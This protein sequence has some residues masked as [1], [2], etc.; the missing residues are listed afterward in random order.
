[1]YSKN[2]GSGSGPGRHQMHNKY[3]RFSEIHSGQHKV[4]YIIIWII[5]LELSAYQSFL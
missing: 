3:A 4:D 2:G 5:G 1:M